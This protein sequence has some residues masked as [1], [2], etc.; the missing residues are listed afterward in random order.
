LI[1]VFDRDENLIAILENKAKNS[2]PYYDPLEIEILNGEHTFTFKVPSEHEDARRITERGFIAFRDELNEL[3]LFT[4]TEIEEVRGDFGERII[5]CESAG[6]ELLDEVIEDAFIDRRTPVQA[7]ERILTGT[8]WEVGTVQ[9][10]G[11]HTLT[12]KYKTVKESLQ[13]FINRWSGD[14]RFRVTIAGNKI[15]RRFVDFFT[16]RGADRGKRIEYKKDVQEIRRTIDARNV[17]TALFGLGAEIFKEDETTE[18]VTFKELTGQSFVVDETARQ[19]WGR[20]TQGGTRKHLFGVFQSSTEN[21]EQLLEQ[22]QK[23][24]EKLK[25]PQISYEIKAIDYGALTGAPHELALLGDDVI[26]LDR[27]LGLQLK[28]RIIERRKNRLDPQLNELVIGNFVPTFSNRLNE[29]EQEINERLNQQTAQFRES[30]KNIEVDT[31]GFLREGDVIYTHWLERNIELLNQQIVAGKGTVHIS[32]TEGILITDAPTVADSTRALQLTGGALRIAS[33]KN[34]DGTFNFRTFGTGEG[35]NA[36]LITSGFIKFDRSRGGT[37]TLGGE[38]IG[39]QQDGTPIFENGQLIVL[40]PNK[41]IS[42]ILDGE[43]G[44][45]DHLFVGHLSSPNVNTK[46][47]NDLHLF[48]NVVSGIDGQDRSGSTG[49]PLRTINY[50]LERL[51]ETIDHDVFI[52]VVNTGVTFREEIVVQGFSGGGRIIIV[53]NTRNRLE[54]S[55]Q[56]KSCSCE[57]IIQAHNSTANLPQADK[58]IIVN[59][60]TTSYNFQAYNSSLVIARNIIAVGNSDRRPTYNF[61]GHS[62]YF[63]VQNC[64]GYNAVTGVIIGAYGC[65][66][67]NY[68]NIGLSARGLISWSSSMIGGGNPAPAGSVSNTQLSEG[69]FINMTFTHQTGQNPLSPYS[70]PVTTVWTPNDTKS[71]TSNT[72]WSSDYVYNGK[73]PNDP[74]HWHG[75]IFFNLRNFGVLKNTDGTNRPITRVRLRLRRTNNTGEN[76]ARRP[77]LFTSTHASVSGTPSRYGDGFRSDVAF[78]WGA[79]QWINLPVRFGQQFQNGTAKSIVLHDGALE[80][81]YMRFEPTNIALEITHG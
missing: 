6:V 18:T 51:P 70:P 59:I 20:L 68:N 81:N 21:P 44:G 79:E 24:L 29:Q 34:P 67:D 71:W 78:N 48:V 27:E 35:F 25:E 76:T 26:I 65:R 38:I 46:T 8:R 52:N 73:R 53:M 13:D 22:T 37:L 32:D 61:Y 77:L 23:A 5:F 75:V 4:V 40:N 47:I 72:G 30:L 31:D 1:Y 56:V 49:Q 42:V 7:L 64:E 57:V 39:E 74:P 58:L 62:S 33:N 60:E 17:K 66:L 15:Q 19:K 55:I 69:G 28:A 80:N 45:F 16:R 36:D 11:Q 14:V 2:C 3:I 41:D 54:G 10:T 50:A 43:T 9:G 63:R 12:I